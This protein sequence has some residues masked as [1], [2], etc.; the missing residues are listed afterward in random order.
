MGTETSNEMHQFG[1]DL[2]PHREVPENVQKVARQATFVHHEGRSTQMKDLTSRLKQ[3]AFEYA[4]ELHSI[5]GGQKLE[6]LRASHRRCRR[7][8]PDDPDQG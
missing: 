6:R 3:L 1:Y 4:Q 2:Q 7:H 8:R 5:I